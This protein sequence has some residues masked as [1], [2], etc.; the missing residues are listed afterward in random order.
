MILFV[1]RKDADKGYPLVLEAF[2]R[3]RQQVKNASLVC[4]GPGKPATPSP[5]GVR[6]IGFVD[7]KIK[8]D[9]L[10][11]CDL[12]CVPSEAESFGLIYMEAARYRKAMIARRLP[13]LQELLGAE[14][15]A[16]LLGKT[17]TSDNRV[18]ISAGEL[19]ME[20]LRLLANPG[21]R[22]QIGENACKVSENF[23]WPAIVMRFEQAYRQALEC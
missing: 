16:R 13:V 5:E 8:H 11:A 14:N 10:A 23:L 12:L 19:A 2:V 20:M 3:V 4:I 1:G 21:E 6:E 18:E 9:A 17:E 22:K 7:E 15:A